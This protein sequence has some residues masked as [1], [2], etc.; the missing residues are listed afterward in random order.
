VPLTFEAGATRQDLLG[1]VLRGVRLRCGRRVTLRRCGYP[2]ASA[3]LLAELRRRIDL[4]ATLRAPV[5]QPGPA[6]LAELGC[7]CVLGTARRA[8]HGALPQHWAG[9]VDGRVYGRGRQCSTPRPGVSEK[10][11][12]GDSNIVTP[13]T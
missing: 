11:R 13:V 10:C 3:A 9:G 8:P 6:L 2:Q 5:R 12:P 7:L 1:Q 4:V